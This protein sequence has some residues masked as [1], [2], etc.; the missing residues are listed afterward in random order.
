MKFQ[1]NLVSSDGFSESEE[2]RMKQHNAPLCLLCCTKDKQDCCTSVIRQ[3]LII[4]SH[5]ELK[6]K[7]QRMFLRPWEN[8]REENVR[9]LE[10]WS[11]VC[12]CKVSKQPLLSRNSDDL[13]FPLLGFLFAC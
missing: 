3:L 11:F 5:K 4:C 10:L 1:V 2:T 12:Q 6:W 8:L 9:S 13:S 7:Q